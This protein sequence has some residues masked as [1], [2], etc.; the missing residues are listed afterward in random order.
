MSHAFSFLLP[1]CVFWRQLMLKN[2]FHNL[3]AAAALLPLTAH[4]HTVWAYLS[5]SCKA[6]KIN[7]GLDLKSVI[8]SAAHSMEKALFIS[9]NK[10]PCKQGH[11][12]WSV[13]GSTCSTPLQFA[14]C[15][16]CKLK[17]A[18]LS[19]FVSSLPCLFFINRLIVPE[20]RWA[21]RALQPPKAPSWEPQGKPRGCQTAGDDG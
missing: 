1:L 9:D 11:C 6:C 17:G 2:A 15:L 3:A 21:S 13:F 10:P 16:Q 14:G 5:F 8:Y 20:R 7:G 4:T 19:C 18:G 12:V